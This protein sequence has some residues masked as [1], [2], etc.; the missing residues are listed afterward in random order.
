ME[1][2]HE[3]LVVSYLQPRP[4]AAVLFFNITSPVFILFNFIDGDVFCNLLNIE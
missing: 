3:H 4:Q 2:F 1:A